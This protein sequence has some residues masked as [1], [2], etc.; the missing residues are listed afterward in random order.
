MHVISLVLGLLSTI[1]GSSFAAPPAQPTSI[2]T[3]E[4][5]LPLPSL[6]TSP[7]A[8]KY[9]RLFTFE[10][11]LKLTTLSRLPSDPYYVHVPTT[12]LTL[13]LG[14]YSVPI[15][16]QN[17]AQVFMAAL[18]DARIVHERDKSPMGA[19]RLSYVV[20]LNAEQELQLSFLAGPQISW[21]EW[22]HV[23]GG[24]RWFMSVY[25]FVSL[26]FSVKH[27]GLPGPG[28]LGHGSLAVTHIDA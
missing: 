28:F 2:S 14:Y 3:T 4:A 25:E 23:I 11:R 24:L 26:A 1:C 15:S 21:D 8:S 5:N 7:N 12:A 19:R 10:E 27:E 20:R 16:E 9:V 18:R 13:R 22:W 6:P 17:V